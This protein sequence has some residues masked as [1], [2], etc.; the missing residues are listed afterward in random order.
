[1]VTICI[2]KVCVCYDRSFV[3][4]SKEANCAGRLG[5]PS[6]SM[7]AALCRHCKVSA[8]IATTPPPSSL[9]DRPDRTLRPRLQQHGALLEAASALHARRLSGSC[10][11]T[12]STYRPQD[13]C[14]RRRSVWRA[15]GD[16]GG[17]DSA[18]DVIELTYSAEVMP[19]GGALSSLRCAGPEARSTRQR[20]E[21]AAGHRIADAM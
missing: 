1:M 7:N 20:V 15:M 16:K 4:S 14:Q 3:C 17:G 9:H 6:L 12:S 18:D 13:H 2:Q 10:A 11:S 21:R 19:P 5:I 8:S